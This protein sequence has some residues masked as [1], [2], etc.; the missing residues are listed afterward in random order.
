MTHEIK[1]LF[2]TLNLWQHF[3]KKAVF[4]SVVALDGSSYRRPGVRMIIS[5]KGEYIGAESASEIA[6]SILAEILSKVRH[7]DSVSLSKKT[8]SIH[9]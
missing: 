9:G 3:R 1:L 8:G 4:V 7:Q 6:I 2:Q 5:E